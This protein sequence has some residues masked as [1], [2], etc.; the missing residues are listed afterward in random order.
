MEGGKG[1]GNRK[2]TIGD[3]LKGLLRRS[4]VHG[5]QIKHLNIPSPQCPFLLEVSRSSEGHI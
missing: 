1:H 3:K 2:Q 5:G 4:K